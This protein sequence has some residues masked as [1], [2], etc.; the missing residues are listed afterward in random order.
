MYDIDKINICK[1]MGYTGYTNDGN[2]YYGDS[3]DIDSNSS[4]N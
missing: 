2:N 4:N 1:Y 3:C